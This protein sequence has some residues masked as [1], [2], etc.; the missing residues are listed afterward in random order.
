MNPSSGCRA[1]LA[2]ALAAAV[3]VVPV[4][5]SAE[6]AVPPSATAAPVPAEAFFMPAKLRAPALSP[7][8]RW[9]AV[10]T[11]VPQ[12]RVGIL[13]I[14]LEGDEAQ[15][16]IAASESADVNWLS[17]VNEDWLVFT[18]ADPDRRDNEPRGSGLMTVKRDGSE[19]RMLI[20]RSRAAE[21]PFQR[22]K[23]LPP[24]YAYVGPGP[25]GGDEV[26]VE[27]WKWDAQGDFSHAVPMLLN[28][29]TS[30]LRS[31]ASDAPRGVDVVL[32][33]L[34]RPRV[35][36][37]E[38]DGQTTMHWSDTGRAPWREISRAPSLQRP[39]WPVYVD[40]AN[41]LFV[42]TDGGGQGE[43]RRFDTQ[44]GKLA[45][46]P[47][48][49]TPGFSLS[50]APV[51]LRGSEELL[52]L[53]LLTDARSTVWLN[54]AMQRLQEQVDA[55]LPGRINL[56]DC[57]PCDKPKVVLVSSF[58]DRLP[59]EYLLFRPAQD[60][61]QLLGE[62]RPDINPRRMA[63][64][65]FHRIKARDGR[66]LP[67][68]IT[69]PATASDKP[70]AAAAVVMVHGGP[71][72]RG[73]HWAWHADA[74][75]LASR[76]YVVI[77]PEFRGST[78]YGFDHFQAGWKQQGLAMQDDVSDALKF[79]VDQGLVAPGKACI[80]GGS[81]GGY[82]ALIGLA[83]DPGLYR[84]GVALAAVT[85]LRNLYDMHWSD[86]S[87]ESRR[88]SLPVLV[89][90]RVK[91]E[92]RLIATSPIEQVA[93]IQAPVLLVHGGKDRRVPVQNGERMR[94]ALLKAGKKVEWVLYADEGHSFERPEN[95]VDYWKR[96]ESFLGQH[97]K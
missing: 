70:A 56:I 57:R 50:V 29:V 77:E 68:W 61:W 13:I 90:D 8:G 14:D 80:L 28:V 53:D 63:T 92:A 24:R 31:L 42:S 81:H 44:T 62:A 30:G 5:A 2:A 15:R 83:K 20:Q 48:L 86:F 75:F 40:G 60:K 74:Q 32:D 27:E 33:G 6:T 45:D 47:L 51:R 71:W 23:T 93:R 9:L 41:Q 96:V 43:L 26:V 54:P 17:W 34:A 97:L 73:S 4:P 89:G 12:R 67:V 11:S 66:D 18:V 55:K 69:R 94:D 1:S 91:E 49:A 84:C 22:R 79:A 52:G 38:R 88:Y 59:G 76:G 16:F 35:V 78:G 85:D 72:S 3:W 95:R 46:T 19:S 10:L 7:T 21:D 36:V 82:S 39:F 25:A 87:D 58:A 37:D 64:L 65:S